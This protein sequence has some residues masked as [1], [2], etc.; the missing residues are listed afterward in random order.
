MGSTPTE[1]NEAFEACKRYSQDCDPEEFLRALP[2]RR[3][4]VSS[5]YLDRYEITNEKYVAWLNKP[6]R[7]LQ[8]ERSRYVLTNKLLLLDLHEG[9]SG[10][11]AKD[12]KHLSL[13]HI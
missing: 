11:I 4:T 13:I 5:F 3:V 6:I 7:P 9:A 10:I 1:A 8:L 12:N 2:H